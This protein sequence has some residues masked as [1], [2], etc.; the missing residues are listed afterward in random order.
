MELL[1]W[2]SALKPEK[3]HPAVGARSQSLWHPISAERTCDQADIAAHWC[4][5]LAWFDMEVKDVA[6]VAAAEALLQTINDYTLKVRDLCT[7]LQ[8]HEVE[9]AR[10]LQPRDEMMK[11]RGS[12]D[13]NG[14]VPD[15]SGNVTVG[16]ATYQLRVR[17]R[18]HRTPEIGELP[19]RQRTTSL[20][21]QIE[22]MDLGFNFTSS[23]EQQLKWAGAGSRGYGI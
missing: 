2:D 21:Q 5:C 6:V 15:L 14:F 3:S 11:H 9:S 8:L 20:S 23:Q 10:R 22:R 19:T 4:S 7:E 16:V 1:D 12:L 18:S 17:T 13:A